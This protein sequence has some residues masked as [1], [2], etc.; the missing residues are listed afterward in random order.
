MY[1]YKRG[2]C[3]WYE[4]KVQGKR[5]RGSC[6]TA[7]KDDAE[8]FAER[9]GIVRHAGTR[10]KALALVDA[11]YPPVE[12]P[13][14]PLGG[15]WDA[16]KA[17]AEATGRLKLAPLSLSRRFH[18]V[19]RLVKWARK[20]CPAVKSAEA[21]TGPIAARFAA[22]LAKSK[23]VGTGKLISEKSRKNILGELGTVWRMLEH[24]SADI[25]NPWANL[26]PTATGNNRLEA[27]TREQEKAIFAAAAKV[28]KGWPL[29]CLIARHTG[30]R[31]GDIATL[32]WGAID[33]DRGVIAVRP[34]KTA[35]HGVAVVI[36]MVAPLRAALAAE[37]G[38]SASSE[39]F[40]LP[41]HA[42]VYGNRSR[43]TYQALNFREVL[44]AAG[45]KGEGFTFHSWR[46]TM[47][48]RLAEA[49]ADMETAKRLLGH[50]SDAMSRHYDHDEHL[51]ELRAA[52]EA[53]E[54]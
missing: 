48:S 45:V 44:D 47:R 40:V 43:A 41:F 8:R 50:T 15:I 37:R 25:R 5:L 4:V 11:F 9:M 29:A 2:G 17:A 10:E 31:Y 7:K 3:W 18:V 30:L 1:L 19:Q 20:K 33:F 24:V 13:G 26:A 34:R 21:V 28:G 54:K 35:R 39:A 23:G 36:P 52:I 22:D 14:L 42:E 12:K 16:Y 27:F 46:H 53:A 49:G 6:G 51:A 32:K 38:E